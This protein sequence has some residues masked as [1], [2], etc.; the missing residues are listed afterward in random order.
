MTI[1]DNFFSDFPPVSKE[2]WL[3]QIAKDLKGR[4]LEEL[5]WMLDEGLRVSPFAHADDFAQPPT[6]MLGRPTHWEICEDVLV[7]DP[8]AANRQALEALEGGAEGLRFIFE[9]SPDW[10]D[11]QQVFEKIHLDFI[12]LHFAGAGV[13]GNPGLVLGFLERLAQ[14]R[15]T[16]PQRLCGSFAYDPATS[17]G[18]VDWRYLVDLLGFANTQF[19]RFKLAT[20]AVNSSPS[21]ETLGA[22]LKHANLYFQKLTERGLSASAVAGALQLS[23]VIEKSYF[24]EI[25][26]IRALKLLWLNALQ[27]WGAPLEYPVVEVSFRPEAYSDELYTNMIRATTMAM[28]AVLGGADRLTVLPYDEGREALATYSKPFSRRIARNVQHLLKMEGFFDEIPD[29]A[30]GSYYIEQL[31]QQLAER[32]WASFRQ[33]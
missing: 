8:V 12:G 9:T 27:A 10:A 5:D 14:Q 16:P 21:A 7:A 23:V 18:I 33:A 29:A 13:R 26:R 19:P 24:L 2:A 15:D 11:F 30:A 25:A 6:P 1:S 32:A 3:R 20:I 28:S 17:A 31:T 22:G 4:P